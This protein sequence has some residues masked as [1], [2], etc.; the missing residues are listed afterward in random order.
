MA[1]PF[2]E[3]PAIIPDLVELGDIVTLQAGV[4]A[5]GASFEQT[6]LF[7]DD[8]NV[9]GALTTQTDGTA[10]YVTT[11]PGRLT[12]RVIARNAAGNL[13]TLERS[14]MVT[15]ISTDLPEATLLRAMTPGVAAPG[16][17][18]DGLVVGLIGDTQSAEVELAAT[19]ASG[20]NGQTLEVRVVS[21]E[22][23][24]E[25]VG[26]TPLGTVFGGAVSGTVSVPKSTGWNKVQMRYASDP[27]TV[28]EDTTKWGVGYKVL[29]L[30]QSQ[31]VI[32]LRQA[33]SLHDM[34]HPGTASYYDNQD[35]APIFGL[36]D[37]NTAGG[38]L[39]AMVD[40]FRAFDPDTP[41]MLVREA[42]P[43]QGTLD[44]VDDSRP[45][46]TWADMQE[47]VDAYGGDYTAVVQMWPSEDSGDFSNDA[48][49]PYR[50]LIGDTDW[51]A[52]SPYAAQVDHTLAD[53]L[54]PGYVFA[55]HP[56]TRHKYS[57]G[58]MRASE[59]AVAN[60]YGLPVGPPIVD[61]QLE[62]L[63]NRLDNGHPEPEGPGNIRFGARLGV[64]LA[65]A[66]GL[67]TSQNP[68]I[69]GT[70]ELSADGTFLI[71]PLTPINGGSMYAIEPSDLAGWR[72][73]ND[74]NG[75]VAELHGNSVWLVKDSGTWSPGATVSKVSNL[76]INTADTAAEEI[77]I[78]Q[79]E[80]YETWAPDILGLGIPV[81]GVQVG[82]Q[83]TLPSLSVTSGAVAGSQTASAPDAFAAADWTATDAAN[84]GGVDIAIARL[85]KTN[86]AP[87]TTL[88]Y[89]IDGGA[90]TDAG[91]VG[92]F[93]LT[94]LAVD[95][96]IDLQLRVV[97][98]TGAGSASDTKS[99]TPT[100]TAALTGFLRAFGSATLGDDQTALDDFAPVG[101]MLAEVMAN[102]AAPGGQALA[103]YKTSGNLNELTDTA[104]TEAI[105]PGFT[106]LTVEGAF[107]TS[108]S[109][110]DRYF[111]GSRKGAT[112]MTGLFFSGDHVF[113]VTDLDAG[114]L[115]YGVGARPFLFQNSGPQQDIAF[116]LEITGDTIRG[117]A[118]PLSGSEPVDWVEITTSDNS[119]ITVDSFGLFARTNGTAATAGQLYW[120]D[121]AVSET[122]AA[123][124]ASPESFAVADW[125][126]QDLANG[127][128]IL[129]TIQSLPN[130]NGAPILGLEYR[131][132]GGAWTNAAGLGD[133][134]IS[135]LP[136]DAPASIAL[137]ALNGI[138][139]SAA[140]DTK[141][142][143]PTEATQAS[144]YDYL[145]SFEAAGL[146]DTQLQ[147]DAF[148][149]VG[150]MSAEVVANAA[151][152]DGKALAFW[153]T[154]GNLN[155]LTDTDVAARLSGGFSRLTVAGELRTSAGGGDRYFVGLRTGGARITGLFFSG[156]HV[157][158]VTDM[159]AGTLNNGV[160]G[161]QFL[162]QGIG[163]QQNVRFAFEISGDTV[164]AKAWPSSAAEPAGYTNTITT[165]DSSVIT[166]DSFGLFARTNGSVTS[167]GQLYWYGVDLD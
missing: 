50:I 38:G 19:A 80:V 58:D 81:H 12:W 161:R 29:L 34:Q 75:F 66:L 43:G 15:A 16:P 131:V 150:S 125:S 35:A 77:R 107:R 91:G 82:G 48:E 7:L 33:L 70:A 11:E 64:T 65:R 3:P 51:I 52:Q 143:T 136:V 114:T 140:S 167:A 129:V 63:G 83:W 123:S 145:R 102:A 152:P 28:W 128:D 142:V 166:A 49:A 45:G 17:F 13:S 165:S 60:A 10:T 68:Y 87:L 89:R 147:L 54:E 95:T 139:A 92:D 94:G 20:A 86:G 133:F 53:V 112:R 106:T 59:I 9:T 18:S 117:K 37:T 47:R 62:W 98:A 56:A 73:D 1:S 105:S 111:I 137:R 135:G 154:T 76:T 41:L 109:G 113:L 46:R 27:D 99:A 23:D 93:T 158:L 149:P 103:F 153:K 71:V 126:A 90:W 156:D 24:T 42:I 120:Y 26:W 61:F 130:A 119:D 159:D 96:E 141:T 36:I 127:G 85:P 2:V 6:R 25:Q 160:G 124:A 57:L 132:D 32:M 21:Q 157:F 122:A 162:L 78:T 69:T 44:L 22:G 100:G 72:V 4:L 8:A 155:E 144:D 39:Q 164:Q 14:V 151:A 97:N 5:P 108:S 146:G 138:G 79:G 30:G 55:Q 84:G 40:Q 110:S 74:P 134:T 116:K 118:W 121:V 31:V 88:E 115:D 101:S 67:D 163:A 148:V 104:V